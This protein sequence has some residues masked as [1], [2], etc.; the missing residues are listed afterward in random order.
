MIVFVCQ[1]CAFYIQK[2]GHFE[3]MFIYIYIYI[4]ILAMC[5]VKWHTNTICLYF[6]AHINR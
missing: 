1:I 3:A 2:Q 4:Y 6:E 5:V